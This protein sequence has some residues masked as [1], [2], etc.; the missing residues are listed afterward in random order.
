MIFFV[1]V[2]DEDKVDR[3]IRWKS[4]PGGCEEAIFYPLKLRVKK[5]ELRIVFAQ[6]GVNPEITTIWLWKLDLLLS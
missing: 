2:Q 4:A 1:Q 5:K 6:T 3:L